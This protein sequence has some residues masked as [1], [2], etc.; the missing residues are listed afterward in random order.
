MAETTEERIRTLEAQVAFFKGALVVGGVCLL[1]FLGVAGFVEIPRR[2]RAEVEKRVG[3]EVL[4][5]VATLSQELDAVDKH[6][7]K[8]AA[9]LGLPAIQEA[10]SQCVRYDQN[11]AIYYPHSQQLLS[12][13]EEYFPKEPTKTGMF[14][15]GPRTLQP[16]QNEIF[17]LQKK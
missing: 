9:A 2:V 15:S 1:A 16:I 7:D 10:L 4:K 14:L 17:Q 13:A 8:A 3:T 5:R 12:L 6:K 11:I